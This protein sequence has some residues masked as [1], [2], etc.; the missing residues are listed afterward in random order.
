MREKD[1]H[2][3]RTGIIRTIEDDFDLS[4][5]AE[6]GQCFR[7]EAADDGAYRIIA[8]DR[9]VYVTGAGGRN[10]LFECGEKEFAAVWEPYFDL[11]QSY[12]DIRER[13][14]RNADP[15]LYKAAGR[16]KGIRILRQDPWEMLIT[17]VITQNRNIPAIRRSV[18]MICGMCGDRKT[19]SRGQDY[20]AF[21]SPENLARLTEEDQLKC[22]LGYR[23][24][25]VR[26]AAE[27]VASGKISLPELRAMPWRD[28]VRELTGLYG[29]G[30]KVACCVALF[31]LHMLDAFPRD[32]WINRVLQNE[33]PQGYPFETYSPY[34]G[35]YQQ[36]MFYYCRNI[37]P[38]QYSL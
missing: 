14:D 2:L 12:R 1:G 28:A 6:S 7:W 9:C 26:A 34:N 18:E 3:P 35:V 31:G 23:A 15:F 33:Y 38:D 32:V 30:E 21:P 22:R 8:L 27:A 4:G 10:Y 16:E 19:D 29:I 17:S 25:Y 36:Y 5:I 13:I 11:K 37:V 20:Y 24:K